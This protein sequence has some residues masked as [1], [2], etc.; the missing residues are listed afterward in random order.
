MK[1]QP[2]TRIRIGYK[3]AFICHPN[4]TISIEKVPIYR[5]YQN[6]RM[7]GSVTYSTI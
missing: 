6:G 5:Y 4:G 1:P 2:T 3:G 7:T